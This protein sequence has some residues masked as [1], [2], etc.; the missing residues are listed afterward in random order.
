MT[1]KMLVED[2]LVWMNRSP[3]LPASEV[4]AV[5]H[6]AEAMLPFKTPCLSSL[7]VWLSLWAVR[8]AGMSKVMCCCRQRYHCVSRQGKGC[9]IFNMRCWLFDLAPQLD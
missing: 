6:A 4:E 1:E 5:S 8:N 9:G 7:L 2:W 3:I